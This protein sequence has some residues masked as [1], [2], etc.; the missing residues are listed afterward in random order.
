[1]WK[2]SAS[3]ADYAIYS[4]P[5]SIVLPLNRVLNVPYKH[6]RGLN[7]QHKH[8]MQKTYREIWDLGHINHVQ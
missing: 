2:R 4:R 5:T 6:L 1:M 3:L 7:S 8:N